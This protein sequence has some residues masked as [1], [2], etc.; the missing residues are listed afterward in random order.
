MSSLFDSSCRD[1]FLARIERLRPDCV[2]AWGKMDAAQ[3]MSH[4]ALA[5]EAAT[6]DAKLHRSLPARLIGWLFKGLLL[7]DKP[8]A[9]NAPTHPLLVMRAPAEFERERKRLIGAI[10]KFHSA[11]PS[12]AARHEHALVGKLTG[13]EWGRMQFKHVDHHLRQ[14][15]V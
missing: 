4:C 6:G 1:Q 8:F 2:R 10:T 3:M 5:L 14:F 12:S 7:N 15:G 13:D 9:R 11:G